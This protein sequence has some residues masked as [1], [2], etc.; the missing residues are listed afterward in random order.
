MYVEEAV[1]SLSSRCCLLLQ[2]PLQH[3]LTAKEE[4]NDDRGKAK[5][6]S[7]LSDIT[8][9][10]DSLGEVSVTASPSRTSPGTSAQIPLHN[11]GF[12]SDV[13]VEDIDGQP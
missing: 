1:L 3:P 2:A 9:T 5:L 10:P 8:T 12:R 4:E 13:E 11:L 7:L 6:Y